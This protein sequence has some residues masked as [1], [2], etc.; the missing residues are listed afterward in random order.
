[1]C[2]IFLQKG[3]TVL[4]ETNGSCDISAISPKCKRIVDIKCP[5]SG[6][7][8]SFFEKNFDYVTSF[9]EIKC[10]ISDK[11]DFDWAKN[12]VLSKK[13]NQLTTVIFSPNLDKISP[14]QIAEWI[15]NSSAPVRLGIQIHKLI[16]G[17]KR[18]V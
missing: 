4:V 5:S 16:W 1:L 10:V 18:G 17:N 14:A 7:C 15:L 3:Y 8:G 9:D 2:D 13:L 12:L 11:N 6:A